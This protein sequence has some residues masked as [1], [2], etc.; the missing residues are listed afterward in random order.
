M[1]KAKLTKFNVKIGFM[2][3]GSNNPVWIIE[4]VASLNQIIGKLPNNVIEFL[5]KRGYVLYKDDDNV[6]YNISEI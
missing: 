1:A 6:Y 3:E 5:E 4:R 2:N